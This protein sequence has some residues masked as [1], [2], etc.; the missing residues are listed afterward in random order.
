MD[1]LRILAL[2]STALFYAAYIIK[3]L[4]LKSRGITGSLLAKGSKPKKELIIEF[5]LRAATFGG[6]AVQFLSVVIP[7]G[8]LTPYPLSGFVRLA[9]LILTVAGNI[10]FIAAM[11]EMKNNWRA[12]FSTDQNTELVTGG[13]YRISR[14]PAFVGF[15]L[16][17]VGCALLYPNIINI[18][19]TLIALA[20]FHMQIL[21]EEKFMAVEF[22]ES[23]L[24]Y[25][26]NVRRYL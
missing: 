19:V 1:N 21:G 8:I 17:Y 2:L 11:V 5:F 23:Y 18:A 3:M 4:L 13:I 26:G 25:K 7:Y 9:G 6:A 22:G 16:V 20:L 14:N 15:D 24:S 12:G 10:F